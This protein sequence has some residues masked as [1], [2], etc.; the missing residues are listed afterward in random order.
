MGFLD[1]IGV[2]INR[3]FS[4]GRL[5][6]G[7][8]KSGDVV[9][10]G[11]SITTSSQLAD[12]FLG[13]NAGLFVNVAPLAAYRLYTK[14]SNL[15]TAI[16]RI[17]HAIS[18]LDLGLTTDGQDFIPVSDALE[19]LRVESEAYTKR[20]LL[21]EAATSFLLTNEAWL[22][23]RGNVASRPVARTWIL[24]FDISMEF[25]GS[26]GLPTS[27]RT[28]SPRDRRVY[29]REESGGSIR[30]IDSRRMNELV[31]ILGN[32]SPFESYRGQSPLAALLYDIEQGVEG[33][34]HNT[35]LLKNGLRVSSILI[36]KPGETLDQKAR[37]QIAAGIKAQSG[38]GYAGSTLVFEKPLDSLATRA[39]SFS[40]AEMDYIKLLE[41]AQQAVYNYYGIPLPLVM[42]DAATFN[43]Y[44]TAQTSFFDQA[45]FP[46]FNDLADA[47]T[48]A[49]RAR[50]PALGN[51]RITY[52]ENTIPA[53]QGRNIERMKAQRE[54]QAMSTDEIR[55]TAGLERV[56]GG[57]DILINAGLVPLGEPLPIRSE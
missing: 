55:N 4:W 22:V 36:P 41:D 47:I 1:T 33:K 25:D 34:R 11:D 27:I 24:P 43:N 51:A 56:D 38:A 17:A 28:T 8:L 18:G 23:L 16:H 40:N 53:L 57:D 32:E 3:G 49:L 2:K 52:N 20:R 12:L 31:Y 13:S 37:D 46:P 15:F 26:D 14:S 50:F 29:H 54:T 21:Y 44:G 9:V 5:V 48:N 39:A 10:G 35:S 45:V 19:L 42:N 30:W 7:F 6:P